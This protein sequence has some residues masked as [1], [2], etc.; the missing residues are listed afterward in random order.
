M[1]CDVR[2]KYTIDSRRF[3]VVDVSSQSIRQSCWGADTGFLLRRS[4]RGQTCCYH[5]ELYKHECRRDLRR[6]W[7]QLFVL[8]WKSSIS[9]FLC[10]YN[11]SIYGSWIVLPKKC[12]CLCLGSEDCYHF[13]WIWIIFKVFRQF[14]PRLGE[15]FVEWRIGG[16]KKLGEL[17]RKP[18]HMVLLFHLLIYDLGIGRASNN[19]TKICD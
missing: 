12:R 6:H 1:Q 7:H 11:P 16:I 18:T 2:L 9:L 3:L 13:V 4:M 19:T 14:L 15:E 17:F 8:L 5:F 10:R